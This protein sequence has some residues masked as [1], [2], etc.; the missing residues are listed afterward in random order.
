MY[1]DI[2]LK[3]LEITEYKDDK[4]AFLEDFARITNSQ[5]LV[6]LVQ[7]LSEEKREE[8][9]AAIAGADS[10]EAFTKAVNTYFSDNQVK[11]A[12][13]NASA[14]AITQWIQSVAPTLNDEQKQ[15]L[16][17][18]AGELQAKMESSKA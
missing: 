13:D 16:A 18:L 11:E 4:K 1:N 8:A 10:Q 17:K 7:T 9:D 15:N 12:L 6:E 2:I 14:Q 5:A 3:L